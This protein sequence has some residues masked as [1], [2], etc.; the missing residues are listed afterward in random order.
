MLVSLTALLCVIIFFSLH[1]FPFY[2]HFLTF[3]LS[4]FVSFSHAFYYFFC[5]FTNLTTLLVCFWFCPSR[6]LEIFI[7]SSQ[8]IP[9]FP[10]LFLVFSLFIYFSLSACLF[11]ILFFLLYLLLFYITLYF[12]FV[13]FC[14]L[15]CSSSCNYIFFLGLLAKLLRKVTIS[16]VMNVRPPIF[17]RG[18]G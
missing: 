12:S 4:I 5:F 16:L 13:P 17:L 15:F 10:Y 14:F 1:F 7:A 8:C 3:S 18:T 11:L 2:F 9:L 6:Q